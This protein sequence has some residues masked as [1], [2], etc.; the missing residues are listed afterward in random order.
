MEF[1]PNKDHVFHEPN[2]G[3]YPLYDH[4]WNIH[5]SSL[6]YGDNIV[7]LHGRAFKQK[8]VTYGLLINIRLSSGAA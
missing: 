5:F 6:L 2:Q 7:K 8:K 4:K 1:H 3:R